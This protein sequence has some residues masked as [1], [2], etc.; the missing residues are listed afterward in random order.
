MRKTIWLLSILSVL[1][2][3]GLP[4]ACGNKNSTSP[5]SPTATVTDTNTPN[6][7]PTN[8]GTPTATSTPTATATVTSTHTPTLTPTGTP[9]NSPTVTSTPL[10]CSSHG[11][12]DASPSGSYTIANDGY[13][14]DQVTFSSAVTIYQFSFYVNDTGG[15]DDGYEYSMFNSS[16]DLLNAASGSY[17]VSAN[18]TGWVTETYSTPFTEAA[19]TYYLG[20]HV[21]KY[22][23][24][25]STSAIG[26]GASSCTSYTGSQANSFNGGFVSMSLGTAG[27]TCYEIYIRTCP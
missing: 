23:S 2:L 11:V 3:A 7:T 8:T 18:Q 25:T 4:L 14:L 5:N 10:G 9:T 21:Y 24:A 26:T 19:G 1:V 20:V 16:G 6:G 17:Y 13:V 27:T 15:A 12:D 22:G